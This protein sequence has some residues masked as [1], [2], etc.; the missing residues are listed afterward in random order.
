[1]SAATTLI[2]KINAVIVNPLIIL[3]FSFALVGFLWGVRGYITSADDAEARIKGSQHMLWGVIGMGLMVMA[4]AI[5]RI[6]INTFGFGK[7]DFTNTN[8]QKVLK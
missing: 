5:Q 6:V 3:M 1:M 7:D 4:F 8:I 2:L